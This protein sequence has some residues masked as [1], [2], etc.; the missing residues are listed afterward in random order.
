MQREKAKGKREK[1]HVMAQWFH[2]ASSDAALP[3]AV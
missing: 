2:P 3:S 1:G